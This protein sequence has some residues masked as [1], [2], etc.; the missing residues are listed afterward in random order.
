MEVWID[1]PDEAF[2]PGPVARLIIRLAAG[3]LQGL[4]KCKEMIK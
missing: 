4:N 1:N 2:R 3:V